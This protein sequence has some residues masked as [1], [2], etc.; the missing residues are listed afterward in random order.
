MHAEH[1]LAALRM[2]RTHD[3]DEARHV[4]DT[5]AFILRHLTGTWWHRSTLEGHVTA[6]AWVVDDAREHALLLHHAKLNRWL[7]PGGHLDAGDAT[8]AHGALREALE[9]TG[10]PGLAMPSPELFDV[11]VHAI[12]ARR[13]EP[14]HLH[15]DLRYLIISPERDARISGESLGAKWLPID[16]IVAGGFESSITRMALKTK[17]QKRT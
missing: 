11:D 4:A 15:Y 17:Q 1:L 12:A 6:S 14:A 9:E 3:A 8:A 7:Q 10:L 5:I 13:I 2:H 16:T